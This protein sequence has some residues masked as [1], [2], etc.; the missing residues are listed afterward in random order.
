MLISF[1]HYYMKKKMI[2]ST[3]TLLSFCNLNKNKNSNFQIGISHINTF[4]LT[5]TN[6]TMI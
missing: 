1:R 5:Q 2:L 6:E 3:I 4:L